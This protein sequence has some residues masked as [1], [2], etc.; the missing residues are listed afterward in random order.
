M[1]SLEIV[2][3]RPG[4]EKSLVPFVDLVVDVVDDCRI[5]DGAK[6]KEECNI[7]ERINDFNIVVV[8][9]FATVVKMVY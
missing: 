5:A 7:H 4:D 8:I 1:P 9:I 3:M 6:P 2:L